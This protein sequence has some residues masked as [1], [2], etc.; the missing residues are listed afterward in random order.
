MQKARKQNSKITRRTSPEPRGHDDYEAEAEIT[1]KREEFEKVG[2][3][4]MPHLCPSVPCLWVSHMS[5]HL[6]CYGTSASAADMK[7][8]TLSGLGW[9]FTYLVLLFVLQRKKTHQ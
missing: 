8:G 6:G 7:A 1:V 2:G 4:D 3:E 9:L 5:P